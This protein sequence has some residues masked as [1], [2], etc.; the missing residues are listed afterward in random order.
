LSISFEFASDCHWAI[1]TDREELTALSH[2][3]VFPKHAGL[4]KIFGQARP[5]IRRRGGCE[6]V[7][8]LRTQ[9]RNLFSFERKE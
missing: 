7:P 9:V 4:S 1:T 5:M 6:F 2:E 8:V 3:R